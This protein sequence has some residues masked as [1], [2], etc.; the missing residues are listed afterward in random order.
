MTLAH[1]DFSGLITKDECKEVHSH[2]F[3]TLQLLERVIRARKLHHSRFFAED[4][5]YGHV[6]FL[7]GLQSRKGTVVSALER[8]ERRMAEVLFRE[9]RWFGWVRECLDEEERGREKEREKVKAEAA[10]FKRHWKAAQLR[11]RDLKAR[12]DKKRQDAYLELAYKES[13]ARKES[14]EETDDDEMDWDPIEDVLEDNRRSYLGML[15]SRALLH[16]T[17]FFGTLFSYPFRKSTYKY[18]IQS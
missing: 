3:L 10:L 11:A 13:L 12:E 9:E 1:Q 7:E 6:K 5:D 17:R 16:C 18:S 15:L 4:C 8:L 2:L 14:G